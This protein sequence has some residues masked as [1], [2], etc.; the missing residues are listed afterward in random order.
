[1]YVVVLA[2]L[3]RR[4]INLVIFDCFLIC[5]LGLDSLVLDH[6]LYR[7]QL[8]AK[9]ILCDLCSPGKVYWGCICVAFLGGIL[10]V[11]ADCATSPHIFYG[12]RCFVGSN[13]HHVNFFPHYLLF[14]IIVTFTTSC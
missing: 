14:N 9:Q 8:I 11:V 5:D 1:M 13:L 3:S 4:P 10:K 2:H 7:D 6:L 12:P